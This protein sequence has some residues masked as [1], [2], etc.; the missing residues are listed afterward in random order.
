MAG[1]SVR[2]KGRL[3]LLPSFTA[4]RATCV[5]TLATGLRTLLPSETALFAENPTLLLPF[6]KKL[7]FS[8][9]VLAIVPI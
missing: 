4:S 1:C 6:R 3:L 7:S 5:H 2:R 9:C 8:C